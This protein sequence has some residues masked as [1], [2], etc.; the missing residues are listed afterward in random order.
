MDPNFS[1]AIINEIKLKQEEGQIH[2]SEKLRQKAIKLK[3]IEIQG[4]NLLAIAQLNQNQKEDAIKKVETSLDMKMDKLSEHQLDTFKRKQVKTTPIEYIEN[5]FDGYSKNFDNHLINKLDY[6][7][8]NL[9]NKKI[10]R[11]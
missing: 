6:K 10:Q 1:D 9:I 5:V 4:Y 7:L 8:P 2:E 3:A 11:K